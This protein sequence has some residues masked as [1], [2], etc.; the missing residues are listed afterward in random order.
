MKELL[1][2]MTTKGQVTIPVEIRRLLGM[3][4]HDKIAFIVEGDRVRL[5]RKGSVVARTSGIFKTSQSP[6]S[7]EELREAA[8]CAVA[9]DVVERMEG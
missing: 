4:K 9:D 6:L 5:M 3:K 2:T 8:E 7:V 1:S